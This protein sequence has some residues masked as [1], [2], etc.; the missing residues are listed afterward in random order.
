MS[1][2]DKVN[3]FLL[4]CV[5]IYCFSSTD[6]TEK[7]LD[8]AG[9]KCLLMCRKQAAKMTLLL[10]SACGLSSGGVVVMLTSHH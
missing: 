9:F 7:C 1:K 5:D 2:A 4:P 6:F 3:V 10:S 8:F